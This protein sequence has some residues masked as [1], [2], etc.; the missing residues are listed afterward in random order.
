MSAI[1]GQDNTEILGWVLRTLRDLQLV[2]AESGI[3]ETTGLLGRGIGLDSVEALRLVT[4]I[5]DEYGLTL[6]DDELTADRFRNVG[7]VVAFVRYKLD[8]LDSVEDASD[9]AAT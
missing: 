8:K 1:A 7:A 9:D 3:D 5:E 2:D 4:A 6:E